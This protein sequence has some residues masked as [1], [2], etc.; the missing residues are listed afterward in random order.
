MKMLKPE[1]FEILLTLYFPHQLHQ[2]E[3]RKRP[4]GLEPN[5]QQIGHHLNQQRR[6]EAIPRQLHCLN[7]EDGFE[8]FPKDLHLMMLRPDV[9]DFGT[10]QVGAAEVH[11]VIRSGGA[12]LEEEE[13]QWTK[14][15]ACGGHA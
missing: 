8:G 6:I 4:L 9:P 15:G 11:Q 1:G 13:H 14:G 3:F 5:G 7:F 10:S 12:F 2:G